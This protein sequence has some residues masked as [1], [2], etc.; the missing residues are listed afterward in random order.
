MSRELTTEE[1]K[2]LVDHC[3]PEHAVSAAPGW[4][5]G[6]FFRRVLGG[7]MRETGQLE[8]AYLMLEPGKHLCLK[9]QD[10]ESLP[11]RF[12][13]TVYHGTSLGALEKIMTEVWGLRSPRGRALSVPVSK[14]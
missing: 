13:M 4:P 6:G 10:P 12:S 5:P 2:W 3:L 1:A 8:T 9:L 7:T 11:T 14:G